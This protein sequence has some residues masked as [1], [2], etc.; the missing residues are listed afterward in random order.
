MPQWLVFALIAV[1]W[2]AAVIVII[3]FM[4]GASRTRRKQLANERIAK[5]TSL[6]NKDS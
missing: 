4:M 6:A 3:V 2:A 5:E 1:A